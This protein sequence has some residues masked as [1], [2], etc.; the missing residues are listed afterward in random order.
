MP[1]NNIDET[2]FN[3]WISTARINYASEWII[4]AGVKKLLCFDTDK[5]SNIRVV[6]DG[7]EIYS[8][9]SFADAKA[10]YDSVV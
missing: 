9:S 7:S 4:Q 8:G 1:V 6:L 2:E 10:A 3:T 5:D